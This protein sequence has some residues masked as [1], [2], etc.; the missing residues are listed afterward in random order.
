M[1]SFMTLLL[2]IVV[3]LFL[4]YQWRKRPK[5]FPPGPQGWPVLGVAHNLTNRAEVGLM[6]KEIVLRTKTF[7]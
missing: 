3:A 4:I 7:E 2:L 1:I 5:N 6:V